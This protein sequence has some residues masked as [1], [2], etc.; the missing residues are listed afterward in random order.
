[1]K[2]LVTVIAMTIALLSAAFPA[3]AQSRPLVTEDP[4]TV[5]SGHMLVETGL[6]YQHQVTYPASGLTGNLWRVATLGLS[7]GVSPIAEI[8]LDGGVHNF[9]SITKFSPAPL[10]SMLTVVGT[11]TSD[12]EDLT[13]G[14]KI[15]FMTE[16]PGRPAMAVRFFTRLPNAGNESGLGLDTTDF[17]FNVNIGKTVQSVRVVGNFGFGI[18][19]D[20]V[21]GDSQ[22]DVLNYG[23]SVARA[24]ATGVELV[25]EING[26]QNTRS[27]TPP[28]GTESR[29]VVRLGVRYTTGPV[30][31]DAGFLF[32]ITSLDPSW[33]FTTGLTWVFK[34]FDVQ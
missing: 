22:N 33:G 4:E 18:L 27:N 30:R 23:F 17:N 7:F 12:F 20:P 16:T 31:F 3:R 2:R 34:A 21:R 10:A 5:P 1:M 11:N 29:S 19:G 13:I 14:A 28:V 25:G 24:V 15:K 32:G 6:D 26:R 9:L 8:Q